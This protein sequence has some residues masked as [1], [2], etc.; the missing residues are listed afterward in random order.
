MMAPITSDF[1]AVRVHEHQMA[2]TASDCVPFRYLSIF[3]GDSSNPR[4]LVVDNDDNV[5]LQVR[6]ATGK[7]GF[8]AG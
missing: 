8:L 2:L 1:N 6:T 3:T 4:E 5:G 7:A